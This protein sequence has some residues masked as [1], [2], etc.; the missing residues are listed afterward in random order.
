MNFVLKK[1]VLFSP[2]VFL[3]EVDIL[4]DLCS[5]AKSVLR[6]CYLCWKTSSPLNPL[7]TA[8]IVRDG[9]TV[10]IPQLGYNA[11]GYFLMFLEFLRGR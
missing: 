1:G 7:V 11:H 4:Y 5:W 10:F 9:E 6:E 8:R 2:Y 3:R